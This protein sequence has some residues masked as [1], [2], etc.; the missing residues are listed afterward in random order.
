MREWAE[1]ARDVAVPLDDRPLAAAAFAALA[2][3]GAFAGRV[4]EADLHRAEAAALVDA[5]S[6]AELALR[7]DAAANLAAAELYL[8]RFDEAAAHAERALGIGRAT[9]QSGIVP[10]LFPTM[11]SA[12]RMRGRLAE[13]AELLDRAVEA[14]RLSGHAQGLAWNL[15]NRS[16]TALQAGDVELALETAYESME[17]LRG[18]D[19]GLV[20][21]YS[22]VALAGALLASGDAEGAVGVL[23]SS[24]G[25]E[26]LVR[27]PAAGGRSA[28]TC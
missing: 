8:D 22:G 21:A 25:G 10:V 13:S 9:G 5:L 6:D 12:A 1:R 7:L 23:V 26:E 11:G 20:S 15:L 16:H 18:L 2:L 4:P 3:A 14:A 24:A 27:I 19:H 28:S 17:L